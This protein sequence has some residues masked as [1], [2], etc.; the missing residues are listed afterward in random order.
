MYEQVIACAGIFLLLLLCL[1]IIGLQKLVL[2]IYGIGLRLGLVGLL[3]VATYFW[4]RPE[5]L[6]V[7]VFDL[8]QT[9]PQLGSLL[10][11]PGTPSF[12]VCAAAT[13][14]VALLPLLMVIDISRKTADAY[15][16]RPLATTAAAGNAVLTRPTPPSEQGGA[17]VAPRRVD[18]RA[19][20]NTMANLSS[21]HPLGV[22]D[23]LPQ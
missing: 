18:R 8:V 4:F 13:I 1:P 21:R 7:Q 11:E 2:G 3:G 22:D 23:G 15:L 5:Q 9:F 16:R 19:A 6:P 17:R 14:T 20:A 10:P 12:G